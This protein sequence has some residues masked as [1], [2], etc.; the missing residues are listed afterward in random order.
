MITWGDWFIFLTKNNQ[1]RK[2]LFSIHHKDFDKKGPI[3]K[4]LSLWAQIINSKKNFIISV[5]V[6][7]FVGGSRHWMEFLYYSLCSRLTASLTES[8][9]VDSGHWRWESSNSLHWPRLT[10]SCPA[11]HLAL[12]HTIAVA[13]NI[14]FLPCLCIVH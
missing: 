5:Q 6:C 14:I 2:M 10:E 8:I 1:S 9:L 13:R 12:N 11:S 3:K 4:N 7:V